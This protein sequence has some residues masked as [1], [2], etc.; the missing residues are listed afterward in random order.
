MLVCY[1]TLCLLGLLAVCYDDDLV[2]YCLV[3][4]VIYDFVTFVLCDCSIFVGLICLYWQFCLRF[5][6]SLLGAIWSVYCGL[7][8][9]CW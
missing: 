6:F 3:G 1:L 4:F 8:W 5:E 7:L 9:L 2:V